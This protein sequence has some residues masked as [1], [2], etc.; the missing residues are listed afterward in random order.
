MYET[1]SIKIKKGAIANGAP[2]GKNK[3]TSFHLCRL[4]AIILIPIKCNRERKKVKIKELV[5]VN[6]YGSSPTRF[7]NKIV[8][9][10]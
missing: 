10:M 9:N 6:E 1:A 5:I 2:D 4:H 8:R 7:A 3:L